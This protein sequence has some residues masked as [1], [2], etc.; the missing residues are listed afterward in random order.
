MAQGQKGPTLALCTQYQRNGTCLDGS[1][2]LA[3]GE[4]ELQRRE[5]A[6]R[7]GQGQR[8][9]GAPA[10]PKGFNYALAPA[11]RNLS[12]KVIEAMKTYAALSLRAA[13]LV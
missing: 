12:P 4:E 9:A 7:E 10:G 1:C 13:V 2:R 8:G 11:P 3:H 6:V 5:R